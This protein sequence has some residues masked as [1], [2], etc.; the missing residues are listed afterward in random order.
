MSKDDFPLLAARDIAY[1]DSAATSQKPKV[2]IDAQ[3]GFYQESNANI[4]RGVHS[5]GFE[6]TSAYEGA[7]LAVA[8]FI[9]ARPS[10]IVFTKNATESINLVVFSF[11]RS[12]LK[13][14]DT[15]LL[16]QMEHHSN[17]IPWQRLAKE[18]GLKL[19]FV[20]VTKDRTLDME[21]FDKAIRDAKIFSFVHVSNVTGAINP[22]KELIRI[23]KEHNVHTVLDASQSVGH[24]NVDVRDLDADF[25]AFSGHKMFGPMGIG[26][27]FGKKHL[28]ESMPPFMSGGGMVKEVGRLDSTFADVPAR[29]EAG[30]PNVAGAVALAKAIGYIDLLGLGEIQR[31]NRDLV[32]YCLVKLKGIPQV[33]LY[34]PAANHSSIVAFNLGRIHAHDVATVLDE[35]GVLVRAGNHC[36]QPLCEAL[37]IDSCCRASFH[38]YN[39]RQDIDR[40]VASL[41]RAIGVFGL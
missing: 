28:L 40:L 3:T 18:R 12:I 41:D 22:A 19:D 38:V 4:S 27:L 15:V 29:F 23:A 20:P 13:E 36:A 26:V 30:T 9:R 10:E 7:R 31:H 34:A 33:T 37:N 39:T 32:D 2:V 21:Y 11:A 1:L 14:G 8:N 17:L 5:L 25:L 24:F 6:A 35:D 16:T